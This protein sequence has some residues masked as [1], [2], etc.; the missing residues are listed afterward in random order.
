[1]EI[2]L[3]TEE[4]LEEIDELFAELSKLTSEGAPI[5]VEGAKDIKALKSLGVEG[6]FYKVS[7]GKSLLNFIEDF[8]GQEEAIILTDFDRAG[9][10][11]AKFCSKHLKRLGVEPV[12]E[13]RKKLKSLVR[14][15]VKDIEGLAKLLRNRRAAF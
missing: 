11:L 7:S 4:T 2:P 12:E 1:V 9:D 13:I 5:I 10:K 3:L 6:K 15:D 8:S 14:R